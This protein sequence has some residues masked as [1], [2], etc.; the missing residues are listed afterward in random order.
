M[1]FEVMLKRGYS[2]KGYDGLRKT[3]SQGEFIECEEDLATLYNTSGRNGTKFRRVSQ[4]VPVKYP[5]PPEVEVNTPQS[6]VGNVDESDP[7]ESE[8]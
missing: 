6:V 7:L 3:Y 1:K 5:K 8:E 2:N 4:R